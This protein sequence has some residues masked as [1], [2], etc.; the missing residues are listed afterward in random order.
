MVKEKVENR[1]ENY[2]VARI[3]FRNMIVS[4]MHAYHEHIEDMYIKNMEG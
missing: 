4:F 3:S 1:L 2:N